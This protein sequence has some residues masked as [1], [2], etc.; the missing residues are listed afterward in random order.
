[1][2]ISR[3][4]LLALQR[5]GFKVPAMAKLLHCS[6]SVVYKCLY[7]ENLPMRSVYSTVADVELC[8]K[9]QELHDTFP[10]SGA[11]VYNIFVLLLHIL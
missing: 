8:K 7:A 2:E 10:N 3:T 9:V 11:K 5:R 6:P 4:Q 1:V